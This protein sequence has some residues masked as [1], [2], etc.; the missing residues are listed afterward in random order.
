VVVSSDMGA[1]VAL[2]V[3]SRG[4][5]RTVGQRHGRVGVPGV[6]SLA[7]ARFPEIGGS[8]AGSNQAKSRKSYTH[9]AF[10]HESARP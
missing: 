8:A 9:R 2:Q 3:H 10:L 1:I 6:E 4:D 7:E 5:E